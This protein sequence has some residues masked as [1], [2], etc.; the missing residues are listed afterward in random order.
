MFSIIERWYTQGIV[1]WGEECAHEKLYGV[2]TNVTY[3][4]DWI[5]ESILEKSDP[6]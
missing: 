4:R 5:I 2:Y 3:F 1:S 6:L